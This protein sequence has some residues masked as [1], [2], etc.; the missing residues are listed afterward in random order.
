MCG[1]IAKVGSHVLALA[2]D[3]FCPW[4][5]NILVKMYQIFDNRQPERIRPN[6][7]LVRNGQGDQA[8]NSEDSDGDQFDLVQSHFWNIDNEIDDQ[9]GSDHDSDLEVVDVTPSTAEAAETS[10]GT[11]AAEANVNQ[12]TSTMQIGTNPTIETSTVAQAGINATIA[13]TPSTQ[14]GINP[15][16]DTSLEAAVGTTATIAEVSAD[17]SAMQ[18]DDPMMASTPIRPSTIITTAYIQVGDLSHELNTEPKSLEPSP[19]VSTSKKK[20][21]SGAY[22]PRVLYPSSSN[23]SDIGT[24]EP[25][26]SSR[27]N[28]T[29]TLNLQLEDT[30]EQSSQTLPPIPIGDSRS[31]ADPSR[32]SLNLHLSS[33]LSELSSTFEAPQPPNLSVT[34]S[35]TITN[36]AV[37]RSSPAAPSPALTR[38]KSRLVPT[39]SSAQ[40]VTRPRAKASNANHHHQISIGERTSMWPSWLKIHNPKNACWCNSITNGLNWTLKSQGI[41]SIGRPPQDTAPDQWEPLDFFKHFYNLGVGAH[42][43]PRLLLQK[44]AT[45]KHNP[46]LLTEQ[47]PAETLLEMKEFTECFYQ[48]LCPMLKIERSADRCS[49]PVCLQQSNPQQ[50]FTLEH[51]MSL[52]FQDGASS[53]CLQE[54]VFRFCLATF[55]SDCQFCGHEDTVKRTTKT[56]ISEAKDGIIFIVK[57]VKYIN[58]Q[59]VSN[60]SSFIQ[61]NSIQTSLYQSNTLVLFIHD[62]SISYREKFWIRFKY[63]MLSGFPTQME[64]MRNM[65][66]MQQWS[67]LVLS[68][69]D[70]TN[71]MS[72]MP[73]V[74]Q[75]LM[76]TNQPNQPT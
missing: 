47:F 61:S 56:L 36:A 70:I 57:R 68:N 48:R 39:S 33:D 55:Q 10:E 14:I 44:L 19:A 20:K 24:S 28:S 66:S 49:N 38:S 29:S 69:L 59:P 43:D 52:T 22:K 74:L 12:A 18:V 60:H 67:I 45:L 65:F 37:I 8:N 32:S 62:L 7:H 23:I 53:H 41:A 64:A 40:A 26:R 50:S 63:Q 31:C 3:L 27:L 46:D 4:D 13:D 5:L 1:R 11:E 16:I 72:K 17:L 51:M 35:S 75:Q 30:L 34:T 58:D 76:T 6:Q 9:Y 25:R 73:G 71:C 54:M 21:T 2:I 15:S 42:A